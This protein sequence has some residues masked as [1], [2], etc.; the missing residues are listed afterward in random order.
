MADLLGVTQYEKPRTGN[1]TKL[2]VTSET[3]IDVVVVAAAAVLLLMLLLL[4]LHQA[5]FSTVRSSQVWLGQKSSK[6]EAVS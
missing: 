4:L 3:T 1:N 6:R 5:D 2:R